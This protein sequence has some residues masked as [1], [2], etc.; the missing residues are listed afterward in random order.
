MIGDDACAEQHLLQN[1]CEKS[2]K[3]DEQ[4]NAVCEDNDE[5]R[6][7][8]ELPFL[9]RSLE[10]KDQTTTISEL[11]SDH[12]YCIRRSRRRDVHCRK[13]VGHPDRARQAEE[14]VGASLLA[15]HFRKQVTSVT[16][17]WDN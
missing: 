12:D 2:E 15:L 9:Y 17:L 16:T 1:L 4:R 10:K 13:G 8:N 5:N 11:T 3:Q 14:S 7:Q 6:C